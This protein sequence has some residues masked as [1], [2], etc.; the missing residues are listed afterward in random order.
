LVVILVTPFIPGNL[1]LLTDQR[2]IAPF[3][4]HLHRQEKTNTDDEQC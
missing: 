1:A 4:D 3:L 2:K